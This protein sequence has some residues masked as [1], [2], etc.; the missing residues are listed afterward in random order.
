MMS[1]D[2]IPL[3]RSV[4]L[5]PLPVGI[6]LYIV[7]ESIRGVIPPSEWELPDHKRWFAGIV[8]RMHARFVAALS[9]EQSEAI[10]ELSGRPLDEMHSFYLDPQ[11]LFDSRR[12]LPDPDLNAATCLR[13]VYGPGAVMEVCD[14]VKRET[15]ADPREAVCYSVDGRL[16]Y[17]EA[18]W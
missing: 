8:R 16:R 6:A 12:Y 11:V 4:S 10:V 3:E 1:L 2:L 15:L 17:L 9:D 13:R 14:L 7:N 5:R 18:I